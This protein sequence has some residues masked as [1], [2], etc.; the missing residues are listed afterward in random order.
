M[1]TSQL[2]RGSLTTIILKLLEENGEMYGYEITQRVKELT[3][4]D[5]EIKEGAYIHH[6]IKWKRQDILPLLQ[7]K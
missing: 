6:Y 3:Q 7:R 2:Y 4:G 5:L 1:S